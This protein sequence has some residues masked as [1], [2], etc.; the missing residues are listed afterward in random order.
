MNCG[1][2]IVV[3]ELWSMNCG[4]W[5]VVYELWSMNCGPWIVVTE[6]WSLNYGQWIVVIYAFIVFFLLH[7]MSGFL[8]C[9][10]RFMWRSI[11]KQKLM[12]VFMKQERCILTAWSKVYNIFTL[13]NNTSI[14]CITSSVNFFFLT[15]HLC[16]EV[17]S[18]EAVH[19]H[20]YCSSPDTD[21]L[22]VQLIDPH[23]NNKK[24][25]HQTISWS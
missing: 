3:N 9:M 17:T 25:C 23:K 10:F 4:Q 16:A 5:I 8:S 13:N 11:K 7:V 20:V 19:Y 18:A 22:R 6:L 24:R 12:T 21:L 2:W 15:C 1:Q 14:V